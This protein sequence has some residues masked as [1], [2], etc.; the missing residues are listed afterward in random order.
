VDIKAVD[1]QGKIY[2]IEVQIKNH[3]ALPERMIFTWSE[4]FGAQLKE[5][6][7]FST[8]Q[9]VIAIWLLRGALASTPEG[10][11]HCFQLWEDTHTTRL[12][13]HCAIHVIELSKW[14]FIDDLD[15]EGNWLYFLKDAREWS[16]APKALKLLEVQE[17]M[18]QMREIA[19][20]D[21][22]W[23][24]YRA[25]Q[26]YLRL[27]ATLEDDK[28]QAEA[29]LAEGMA[30]AEAKAAEMEIKAAEAVEML[31][32]AEARAKAEIDQVRAELERMK[33]KF[34]G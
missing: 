12:T 31:A 11:H 5:G 9:P 27:M 6:E 13:G 28:A 15:D 17:A 23:E 1:Q 21:A 30:K 10:F 16:Q 4:I 2:Q 34:G 3:I 14:K 33:A 26:H 29:R 22:D 19:E 18:K 7:G 8:L 25:R 20:K 32:K 24:R